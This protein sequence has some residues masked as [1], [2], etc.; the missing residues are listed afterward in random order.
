VSAPAPA[1]FPL[2]YYVGFLDFLAANRDRID[3]ITYA[4]LDWAP[5]DD[6]A[7]DYPRERER[8]EARRDPGRIAVFLQ[9]DVDS[10]PERTMRIVELEAERGLRSAVMIHRRRHIRR[11][12]QEEHRLELTPYELDVDLLQRLE[13]E[14]GFVIG[15]HHNAFEQA[16]WDERRARTLMREDIEALRTHFDI[17]FMSAHGGVKS[18]DGKNNSSVKLSRWLRREV[19]WVC[20]G[21]GIRVDGHYEDGGYAAER[22]P[23]AERDLRD[24]V[25]TWEPGKRYRVNV[26][27]Q[28]Y[29]EPAELKPRFA[30]TPWYRKLFGGADPWAGLTNL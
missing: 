1:M 4:D 26:H 3:V 20:T 2:A 29:G 18:P 17:R 16:L 11:V 7:R 8:W 28:Y 23:F 27:P 25:R 5:R 30:D 14:H 24:F 19:R 9:H 12:L 13:R 21:H 15:Y 6:Y 22:V 10:I